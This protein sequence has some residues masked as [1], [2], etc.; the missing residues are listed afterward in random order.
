MKLYQLLV[1][2]LV[3]FFTVT[4]C[5][6]SKPGNDYYLFVGTY[7]KKSSEGIYVFKFDA[8]DGSLTKLR[9]AKGVVD[10]SYLAVSPDHRYLYAVNEYRYA[11]HSGGKLSAF[12]INRENGSLRLIN[13]RSTKGSSPC[14]VSVDH[15]GRFAFAANYSSGSFSMFP[16]RNDGS[17][18]TASVTI[19]H[20]GSSVNKSRQ[21]SPHVHCTHLTPDNKFLIVDDLGTDQVSQYAFNA[22]EGSIDKS[23]VYQYE[24]TPGVGPRHI[25]FHPKGEYAYLVTEMGGSIV[26]FNYKDKQLHP[27]QTISALPDDYEGEISGADIHVS[28]DGRF[29]YASMR[30]DL[31]Q[32]VIFGINPENG[33]LS[34]VGRHSTGGIRPRNFVIDPTGKY[35]LTA[36]MNSDNIVVFKRDQASG[37]ILPTGTQV[38]V[39]MPVCLKMISIN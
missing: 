30:E 39:S 22:N 34:Y 37:K 29:L 24:A 35:L 18:D 1:V 21:G 7:T 9:T 19:E 32:I 28:P 31:N 17:L 33:Q 15:S 8:D 27:M 26:A 2:C 14:Y 3:F 11:G 38:K 16:I 12:S 20:H 6:S 23:P 25:T 13:T 5:Q 4:G 10:P 36:N